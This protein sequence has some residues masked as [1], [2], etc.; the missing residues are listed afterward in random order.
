MNAWMHF[1]PPE[2]D[3]TP[4]QQDSRKRTIPYFPKASLIQIDETPTR[5]IFHIDHHET[6]IGRADDVQI[7]LDDDSVSHQHAALFF[8]ENYNLRVR[9]LG[10]RNGTYLNGNPISDEVLRH[11]DLLRIGENRFLLDFGA[12]K[13]NG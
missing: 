13:L 12:L 7:F 5:K 2:I 6:K 8:D 11:H 10:S 3:L 1:I 4:S 9:D